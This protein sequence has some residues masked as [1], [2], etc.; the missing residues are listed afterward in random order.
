MNE[1]DLSYATEAMRRAVANVLESPL[2]PLCDC[3]DRPPLDWK[4]KR[5][6]H[7]CDCRAV[8]SAAIVAGGGKT[9]HERLHDCLVDL[10]GA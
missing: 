10:D 9:L 4:G 5:M 6:Y 3:R 1:I 2:S 8:L 7:H